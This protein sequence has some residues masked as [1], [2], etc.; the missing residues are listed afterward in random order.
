[1]LWPWGLGRETT[2]RLDSST[3]EGVLIPFG[4]VPALADKSPEQLHFHH[5][6]CYLQKTTADRSLDQS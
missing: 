1:M 4:K 5:G 3:I 2:A 6:S